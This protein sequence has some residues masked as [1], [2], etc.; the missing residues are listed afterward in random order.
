ML[1]VHR[2]NRPGQSVL[3]DAE[4]GTVD[5]VPEVAVGALVAQVVL[6]SVGAED[7]RPPSEVTVDARQVLGRH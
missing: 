5:A 1:V 3:D 7:G 2:H 4:L 6:D